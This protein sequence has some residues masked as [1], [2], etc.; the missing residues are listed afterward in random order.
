MNVSF[1][2]IGYGRPIS[3]LG[4]TNE[5]TSFLERAFLVYPCTRDGLHVGSRIF[6]VV[7]VRDGLMLHTGDNPKNPSIY[8]RYTQGL[9][10][11]FSSSNL[12]QAT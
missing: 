8:S 6:L 9:K 4:S 3:F 5:D 2:W 1:K 10:E 12:S 11:Y 7:L